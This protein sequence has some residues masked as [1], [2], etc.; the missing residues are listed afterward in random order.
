MGNAP[1]E[2]LMNIYPY[3]V[4]ASVWFYHKPVHAKPIYIK[5]NP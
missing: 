3:T 5:K 1:A 2:H 4:I